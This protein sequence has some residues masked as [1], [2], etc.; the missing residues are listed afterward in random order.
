MPIGPPDRPDVAE[1]PPLS[2]SRTR[3]SSAMFV[4]A[5]FGLLAVLSLPIGPFGESLGSLFPWSGPLGG[6]EHGAIG[7]RSGPGIR[8]S[9]PG[10]GHSGGGSGAG[11]FVIGSL[12]QSSGPGGS[13]PGG[14]PVPVPPLPP[15]P[16]LP[17]PGTPTPGSSDGGDKTRISDLDRATL[18]L[19]SRLM[20]DSDV[21]GVMARLTAQSDSPGATATLLALAAQGRLGEV[22]EMATPAQLHNL[23]EGLRGILV[24]IVP[25]LPPDWRH[26]RLPGAMNPGSPD[27]PSSDSAFVLSSPRSSRGSG[28]PSHPAGHSRGAS[29]ARRHHHRH[30]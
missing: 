3:V 2:V 26:E 13:G 30:H 19:L 20:G 27:H 18:E 16:P 17:R 11:A 5:V 15:E 24:R 6:L 28:H 12:G 25:H 7:P 22:R 1:P 9:G 8:A 10:D 4:A 23:L 21:K 29:E 14:G